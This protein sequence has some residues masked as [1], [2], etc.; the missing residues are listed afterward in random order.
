MPVLL[1]LKSFDGISRE[2]N[3]IFYS[4]KCFI[5][6]MPFILSF[7]VQAG[8]GQQTSRGASMAAPNARRGR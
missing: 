4:I 2:V 3:L 7:T 1:S 5:L 6:F 8:F